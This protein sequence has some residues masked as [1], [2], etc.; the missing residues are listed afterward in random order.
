MNNDKKKKFLIYIVYYAV[1]I[2]L[3]C[4]A[5]KFCLNYLLPFVIGT[6]IAVSIQ[7]PASVLSNRIKLKHGTVALLMVVFIYLVLLLLLFL[8]GNRI[9][10]AAADIYEKMPQYAQSITNAADGLLEKAEEMLSKLPGSFGE[11]ISTGAKNAVSAFAGKLGEYVSDFVASVV[12]GMPGFVFS[13]VVTVISGCYIAKD[14]DTFKRIVGY[15]LNSEQLGKVNKIKNIAVNNILKMAK[16]YVLLSLSAFAVLLAGFFILGIDGAAK[17]AFITAL[18]D[19]LPVFGSGTVLLPWAVISLIKGNMVLFLGL[20][21]VFV[22]VTVVRNVLEPKIMG[23]QVGLNP[24]LTLFSLFLGL[25][26]FGV[27]GMFLLPLIVTIVY[28]YAEEKVTA[29]RGEHS[30]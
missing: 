25:K 15:A 16:G 18:V 2:G 22:V 12:S 6:L 14:F 8:I 21:A 27:A 11:Y 17:M 9:Y 5:M 26:L 7:K 1:I 3:F 28:K 29:E 30:M 20:I 13:F 23:K 10:F 24:L 4:F 19:F